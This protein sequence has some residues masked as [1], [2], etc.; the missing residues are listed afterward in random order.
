M[1]LQDL[2]FIGSLI[3]VM[4]LFILRPKIREQKEMTKMLNALK[5]GDK[6]LTQ[7]GMFG[8]VSAIKEHVVTVKVA[9]NVN[10]DFTKT[11]ITK[12]MDEKTDRDASVKNEG[13]DE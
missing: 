9:Q 7:A 8:E 6:V 10:I 1:G 11:A 5:R 2:L 3:L 4:Y 12:V 13:K